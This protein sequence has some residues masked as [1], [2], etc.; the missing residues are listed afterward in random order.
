MVKNIQRTHVLILAA[1]LILSLGIVRHST[2]SGVPPCIGTPGCD[3]SGPVLGM[4]N[5]VKEGYP[6]T[7]RERVVFEPTQRADYSSAS[8]ELEGFNKTN[9]LINTLF[10]YALLTLVVGLF[11][12]QQSA[13][14]KKKSKK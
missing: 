9:V 12:T 1:A 11:A 13:P 3:L 2:R 4:S 7:Y 6:L 5:N 14:K 8:T 10:W